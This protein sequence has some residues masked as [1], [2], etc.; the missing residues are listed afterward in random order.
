MMKNKLL[1]LQEGDRSDGR[2]PLG[3][4]YSDFLAEREFW[5]TERPEYLRN[6]GA[7]DDSDPARMTVIVSNIIYG[8][9]NCLGISSGFH[10]LCCVNQCDA[11]ME[12]VEAGIARPVASPDALLKLVSSLSSDTVA[13]PRNLSVSLRQKLDLIAHHH[14]GKVP[15]HGRLFAQWMHHAFPNECPFPQLSGADA[16]L[17]HEEWMAQMKMDSVASVEVMKQLVKDDNVTE[18]ANMLPQGDGDEAA[19]LWTEDE[20]LVTSLDFEQ[21]GTQHGEQL[22]GAMQQPWLRFVAM[23][24][25]VVATVAIFLDSLRSST[26]LTRPRLLKRSPGSGMWTRW[27]GRDVPFRAAK[28]EVL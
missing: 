27:F 2:V 9:S 26:S 16:P 22:F 12:N 6:L 8:R 24:T 13:A 5:F 20:E 19:L 23:C 4:F 10:S 3:K 14:A 7:L 21:W 11:L 15:L 1:D 25:A 18:S 17:T 28:I